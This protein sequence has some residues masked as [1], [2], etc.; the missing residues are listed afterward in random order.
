MLWGPEHV[1]VVLGLQ[2]HHAPQLDGTA[3]V[4]LGESCNAVVF[5]RLDRRFGGVH[6]MIVGFGV[7]SG[8]AILVQKMLDWTSVF[9]VEY[10]MRWLVSRS[11]QLVIYAGECLHHAG[12][13]L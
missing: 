5:H 7:L 9:V 13:M 3:C 4:E 8:G 6:L 2:D 1:Q 12:I 10:V 11:R